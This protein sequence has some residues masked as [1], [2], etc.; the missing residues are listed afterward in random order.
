MEE[1]NETS[2]AIGLNLAE[3]EWFNNILQDSLRKI[4]SGLEVEINSLRGNKNK[5]VV[6][7]NKD[8]LQVLETRCEQIK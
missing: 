8:R 5:T 1:I 7:K 4:A 6:K 3:K 2:N